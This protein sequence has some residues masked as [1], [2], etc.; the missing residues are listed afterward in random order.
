MKLSEAECKAMHRLLDK[1]WADL[2]P[3]LQ[4]D[5]EEEG[6]RFDWYLTGA[7]VAHGGNG[8]QRLWGTG[9]TYIHRAVFWYQHVHKPGSREWRPKRIIEALR[10]E[11]TR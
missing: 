7:S 1:M 9:G 11:A 8:W 5:T 4:A 6:V 2:L 10:K 3:A